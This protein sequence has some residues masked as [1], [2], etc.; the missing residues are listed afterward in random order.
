M[1]RFIRCHLRAF[2]SPLTLTL[3]LCS[4]PSQ[5]SDHLRVAIFENLDYPLSIYDKQHQL[6]GGIQKEFTDSIARYIGA[7]VVYLPYSRRRIENAVI[8]GEA[9]LLCYFSPKW[10]DHPD[11][12]IWSIASLPQIE[13]VVVPA[14]QDVPKY[15]PQQ[16]IG[17]RIAV[18]IGY[19]Y[20]SLNAYFAKEPAK[21]IDLTDVPGMFKMLEIG[22]ADA[23]ISSES[24]IEG[25]FKQFPEKRALFK[26]SAATFSIMHTQ[27]ALSRQSTWKIDPINQAIRRMQDSGELD[28]LMRQYGLTSR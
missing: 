4:L 22:G 25:F 16:L 13:R 15:F 21:R 1:F 7:N 3:L 20:P 26:T 18:Q 6:T 28:R 5:A 9:D 11:D 14:T 2:L 23:L 12:M 27:C 10:A 17:K 24:E 19:H 8:H